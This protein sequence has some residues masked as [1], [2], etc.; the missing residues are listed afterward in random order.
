MSRGGLSSWWIP[1]GVSLVV[2][3]LVA[4]VPVAPEPP[5][6]TSQPV[7]FGLAELPQIAHAEPEALAQLEEPLPTSSPEAPPAPPAPQEDRV[8]AAVAGPPSPDPEAPEGVT[9]LSPSRPDDGTPDAQVPLVT[10]LPL[11][12]AQLAD[13]G[14]PVRVGN[15][16]APGQDADVEANAITGFTGGGAG[17]EGVIGSQFAGSSRHA[18]GWTQPPRPRRTREPRYPRAAR[19][20]GV[21]GRVVVEVLVGVDGQV[22]R[23]RVVSAVHPDLDEAAR[24]AAL[25]STFEP[26]TRGGTAVPAWT[27]LSFRFVMA[28][29]R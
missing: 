19:R 1:L 17:G 14:M 26:A 28:P 7:R 6:P 9:S 3:A 10:G 20:D 5:P 22:E 23:T 11:E 15:T 4:V 2:H 13:D 25:R 16:F 27:R 21:V 24:R 29:E 12:A 18:Q 8:E